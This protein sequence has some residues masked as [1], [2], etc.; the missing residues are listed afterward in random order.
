MYKKTFGFLH[1]PKGFLIGFLSQC[2]KDVLSLILR[3]V[4][5]IV[6]AGVNAVI[7]VRLLVVALADAGKMTAAGR[8]DDILRVGVCFKAESG[9]AGRAL[10]L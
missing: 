3:L 2:S 1:E 6:L 10:S 4:F 9:V 5:I 7:A 8:A